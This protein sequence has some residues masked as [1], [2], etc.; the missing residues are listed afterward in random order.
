M[1]NLGFDPQTALQLFYTFFYCMAYIFAGA[2][3]IALSV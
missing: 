2:A 1:G 3:V